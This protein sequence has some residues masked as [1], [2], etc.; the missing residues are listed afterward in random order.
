MARKKGKL[1]A[2]AIILLVSSA[3]YA[4]IDLHE[5][6][7]E[8]TNKVEMSGL[9]I[10]LPETK[11]SQCITKQKVIPKS[12]KKINKHCT[13]SEQKIEGDTVTWKMQCKNKIE[14]NGSVIYH[15]DTLEG[16]IKSNTVIPNMGTIEVD[17]HLSG[18][19]TGECKK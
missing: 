12:N 10:K 15:G 3:A 1:F 7:W 17:I 14:S 2:A 4:D 6:M 13:V 11:I 9:P 5:G 8:I 18:R 19:R 16:I